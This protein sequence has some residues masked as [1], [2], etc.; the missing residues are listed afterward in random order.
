[1]LDLAQVPFVPSKL[2]RKTVV[3]KF[4][5]SDDHNLVCFTI[6]IG[7]T[8]QLTGGIKDMS[9]GKILPVKLERIG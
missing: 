7:N 2:L 4:K 8:E 9:T 1:L 6:D 3:S 5:M